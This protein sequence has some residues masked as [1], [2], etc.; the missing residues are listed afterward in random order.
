MPFDINKLVVLHLYQYANPKGEESPLTQ[1]AKTCQA[2]PLSTCMRT[3]YVLNQGSLESPEQSAAYDALINFLDKKDCYSANTTFERL[4][5]QKAYQFLLHWMLGGA[6]PL[7]L[8]DDTRIRG[9]VRKIWDKMLKSPSP[10]TK[11]LVKTY[12]TLFDNLFHDSAYLAEVVQKY[13]S[14][15]P[16]SLEQIKIACEHCA[17]AR[18]HGFFDIINNFNYESFAENTYLQSLRLQL[19]VIQKKILDKAELSPSGE[20]VSFQSNYEVTKEQLN[21]INQKLTKIKPLLQFLESHSENTLTD[22]TKM[23]I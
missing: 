7:K 19:E 13:K 8:F 12:T 5:G 9:G 18:C 21:G 10:K 2:I 1:V 3:I 14:T 11:S 22:P 4:E 15:S 16:P 23:S 17:W 20:V 6:N